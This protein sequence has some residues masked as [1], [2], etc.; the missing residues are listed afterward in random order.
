MWG[1]LCS[2]HLSAIEGGPLA[3]QTIWSDV[4]FRL[5]RFLSSTAR[6]VDVIIKDAKMNCLI[7]KHAIVRVRDTIR[8]RTQVDTHACRYQ[9][10]RCPT[11]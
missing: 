9:A 5:H 8:T 6:G 3:F 1:R 2:F 10:L 7:G 11:V 4:V